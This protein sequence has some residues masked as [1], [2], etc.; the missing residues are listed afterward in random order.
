MLVGSKA[1]LGGDL[2][3]DGGEAKR[4]SGLLRGGFDQVV[5][6]FNEDIGPLIGDGVAG[7]GIAGQVAGVGL[8]IA[9]AQVGL[10]GEAGDERLGQAL[11]GGVEQAD[12]PR[13]RWASAQLRRKAVDRDNDGIGAA[14]GEFGQGGVIGA[15]EPVKAAVDILGFR[16][17]IAGN[18]RAIIQA[19]HEGRVILAPVWV[20]HE[21]REIAEDG[22]A[23]QGL[24][25]RARHTGGPNIIGDMAGH[26]LRGHAKT[27]AVDEFR[28]TIA[29]VIA[30]HEPA[31]GAV[32]A[33]NLKGVIH[34]WLGFSCHRPLEQLRDNVNCAIRRKRGMLALT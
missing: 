28:Y 32:L 16:V 9:D 13:A 31:F 8:V 27:A 10:L 19:H 23:T 2:L 5:A 7:D 1:G 6:Q 17:A 24:G 33:D 12:M 34:H 18:D 21:A 30:G 29:G 20:D 26:I 22:G 25:K 14:C 11:V 3:Q 4:P 15:I